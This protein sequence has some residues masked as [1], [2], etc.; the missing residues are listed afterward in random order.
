[1]RRSR[2]QAD[3]IRAG[4]RKPGQASSDTPPSGVTAAAAY[5]TS[6]MTLRPHPRTSGAGD[7]LGR[8]PDANVGGF[9]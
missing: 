8:Q 7:S 6:D 4:R 5:D 9:R 1:M 2:R 3:D